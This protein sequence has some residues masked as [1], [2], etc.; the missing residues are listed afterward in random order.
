MLCVMLRVMLGCSDGS[1]VTVSAYELRP[2]SVSF[3]GYI[4]K[5]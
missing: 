3:V 2:T 4:W 1:A 5:T